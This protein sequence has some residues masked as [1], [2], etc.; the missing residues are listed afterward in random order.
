MVTGCPDTGKAR[1]TAEDAHGRTTCVAI[2]D[3]GISVVDGWL[4]KTPTGNVN[5]GQRG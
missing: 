1:E 2:T 5:R 3:N 4:T